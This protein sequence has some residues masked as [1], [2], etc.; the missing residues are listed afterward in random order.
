MLCRIL[1]PLFTAGKPPSSTCGM[2]I[3]ACTSGLRL[4]KILI[5]PISPLL[6]ARAGATVQGQR[7]HMRRVEMNMYVNNKRGSLRFVCWGMPGHATSGQNPSRT[8]R[9][10]VKVKVRVGNRARVETP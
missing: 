10:M 7:L 9:V 6:L 2:H 5:P 8:V 3:A 4:R 1:S